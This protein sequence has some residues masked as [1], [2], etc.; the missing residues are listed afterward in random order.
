MPTVKTLGLLHP[1]REAIELSPLYDTV[2]TMLWP[3]LRTD[4]AMRIGG[5][6]KLPRVNLDQVA[7]EATG[8][9]F[10]EQRARERAVE[11]AELVREGLHA[12][13]VD[14]DTPALAAV[15]PRG[16]SSFSRRTEQPAGQRRRADTPCED[17]GPSLIVLVQLVV[18]GLAG[19][20]TVTRTMALVPVPVPGASYLTYTT[21]DPFGRV[22]TT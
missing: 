1:S 7:A 6:V 15:A 3:H 2:P 8:W 11:L 21:R 9:G 20:F 18:L 5:Q 10:P 4:A 22:T 12:G 13:K 19:H 17:A 14:V 16:P